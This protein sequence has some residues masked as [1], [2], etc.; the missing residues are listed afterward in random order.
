[1]SNS[2]KRFF[3]YVM[4]FAFINAAIPGETSFKQWCLITLGGCIIIASV[5]LFTDD[6]KRGTF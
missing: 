1:M 3:G 5:L 6:N 2:I 4:G